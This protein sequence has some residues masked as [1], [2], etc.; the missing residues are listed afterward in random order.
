MLDLNPRYL[1]MLRVILAQYVPD[2][3]VLAYGSRVNGQSH[4]T[5]DLDLVVL[6]PDAPTESNPAVSV[7]REALTESNLPISV[8][9][10]DWARIP[11]TFRIEIK[12]QCVVVWPK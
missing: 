10:L 8:D 9:V 3:Q 11:E 12:K 1:D 7:L 5:S 2:M 4:A 6:N